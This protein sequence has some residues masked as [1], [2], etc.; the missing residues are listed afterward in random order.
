MNVLWATLT[1]LCNVKYKNLHVQLLYSDPLLDTDLKRQKS[2]IHGASLCTLTPFDYDNTPDHFFWYILREFIFIAIGNA[3]QRQVRR[4]EYKVTHRSLRH[5]IL[6]RPAISL[7]CALTAMFVLL[8]F[9]GVFVYSQGFGEQQNSVTF[10]L[11]MLL[12]HRFIQKA[13]ES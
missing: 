2:T 3:I 4:G 8:L 7:R 1:V 12:Y 9:L 10:R 13:N 11:C 5:L 6:S